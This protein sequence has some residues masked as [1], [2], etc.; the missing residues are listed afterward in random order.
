VSPSKQPVPSPPEEKYERQLPK[1]AERPKPKFVRVVL[2][3]KEE[4]LNNERL[5]EM[6]DR[7]VVQPLP[8]RSV[9]VEAVIPASDFPLFQKLFE[10]LALSL[11][12]STL[13]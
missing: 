9:R 5:E 13:H 2:H 8:D 7:L 11:Q 12:V 1:K 10:G 6:S 4:H 3:L